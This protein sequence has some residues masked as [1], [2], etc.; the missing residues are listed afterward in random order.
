MDPLLLLLR[1]AHVGGAVLW[2]GSAVLFLGYVFPSVVALGPPAT[3]ML[4]QLIRRRLPLYFAVVSTTTVV[5]GA[6]LYWRNTGGL[7]S[8][9]VFTDFGLTFL[10][11]GIAGLIA[12]FLAVF[13]VPR[14]LRRVGGARGEI[15]AAGGTPTP[16]AAERLHAAEAAMRRLG[17]VLLALLAFAVVTMSI[18]RYI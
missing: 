2:A 16:D 9:V 14:A 3:P 5:A 6:A 8:S 10:L 18:A 1:I 15:A 17:L 7:Q 4:G 12:W 13:V 11:G